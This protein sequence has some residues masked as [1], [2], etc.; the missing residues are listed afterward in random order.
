[1]ISGV[2][3]GDLWQRWK[4]K[5]SRVLWSSLVNALNVGLRVARYRCCLWT[6]RK[7]VGRECPHPG[8]LPSRR[9]KTAP[10]IRHWPP[11]LLALGR[12][13]AVGIDDDECSP[14][15][16]KHCSLLI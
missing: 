3:T 11:F 6:W 10:K 2:C 12:K 14:A 8:R 15:T 13:D 4:T 16:R 1:M 9:F 7:T 5:A